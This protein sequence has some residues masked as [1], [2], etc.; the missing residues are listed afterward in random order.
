MRAIMAGALALCLIPSGCET[1]ELGDLGQ[2]LGDVV[3]GTDG[4]SGTDG[5]SSFEIEAGLRQALE[6]GTER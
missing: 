2:V 3:G 6:I 1:A 4:A 5:L